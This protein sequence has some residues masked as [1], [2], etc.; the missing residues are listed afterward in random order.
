MSDE[1]QQALDT[2]LDSYFSSDSQDELENI[3]LALGVTQKELIE[4][5]LYDPRF[6]GSGGWEV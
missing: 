1:Q 3:M 6:R 2:C 4:A 5:I